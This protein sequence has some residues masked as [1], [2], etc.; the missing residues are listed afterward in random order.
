MKHLSILFFISVSCLSFSCMKEENVIIAPRDTDNH[1]IPLKE[2]LTSLDSFMDDA[3]LRTR[4]GEEKTYDLSKISIFGKSQLSP[5]TRAAGEKDN[6]PDTLIYIVPF[7]DEDGFAILAA[8]DVLKSTI[9]CVT[10]K[11]AMSS[12]DFEKAYEFLINRSTISSFTDVNKENMED[13]GDS[14][15]PAIM[16][17]SM[18]L[19]ANGIYIEQE[20]G[21]STKSTLDV[22]QFGP[23][24]KTKWHQ[25]S[26]FWNYN[27]YQAVG[28]CTV[29]VGQ[30][31]VANRYAPSMIFEGKTCT[32]DD[33]ESVYYYSTPS[34][35]GTSEAQNQAAHFIKYIMNNDNLNGTGNSGS[36]IKA[37]RV[38][39]NFGYSNVSRHW[40]Y[41]AAEDFILITLLSGYPVYADGL[42]KWS[43]NGHC[44]V[45]DGLFIQFQN[46]VNRYHHINWG[47]NGLWDGYYNEHVYNVANRQFYDNEIDYYTHD[48][49]GS[50]SNYTWDLWFITYSGLSL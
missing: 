45:I 48:Q 37:K 6:L 27:G 4:S 10:E 1:T 40:G 17:S 8:N 36:S 2:A 19:Q 41:S 46:E 16:L 34:S 11:G 39:E 43:T 49:T 26:P 47:W 28:C 38:F 12:S 50:T 18:I 29:A 31:L 15:V 33:L 23:F 22:S 21:E 14:F 42:K 3:G 9:I 13:M 44:W 20:K 35:S 24:V 32:W 5:A 7:S 25:R 30:I